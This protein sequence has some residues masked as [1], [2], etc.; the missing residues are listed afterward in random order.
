[1]K[2][3]VQR[4]AGTLRGLSDSEAEEKM[5]FWAN[6]GD[7]LGVANARNDPNRSTAARLADRMLWNLDSRNPRSN[8][9]HFAVMAPL[10]MTMLPATTTYSG[11]TTLGASTIGGTAL[12]YLTYPLTDQTVGDYLGKLPIITSSAGNTIAETAGMG[13]IGLHPSMRRMVNYTDNRGTWY[14]PGEYVVAHTP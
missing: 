6:V 13:A 8:E 10:T 11:L 1:M 4:G 5:G 3:A 2:K 12:N 9:T 14:A 7:A